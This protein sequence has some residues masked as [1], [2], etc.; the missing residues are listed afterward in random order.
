MPTAANVPPTAPELSKKP[1]LFEEEFASLSCPPCCV[2]AG[3]TDTLVVS[4]PLAVRVK[5]V[6]EEGPALAEKKTKDKGDKE[7]QI[8]F[9]NMGCFLT[10]CSSHLLLLLLLLSFDEAAEVSSC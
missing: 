2:D 6:V 5:N 7:H 8:A 4:C 9:S 10:C 3:T 1:P